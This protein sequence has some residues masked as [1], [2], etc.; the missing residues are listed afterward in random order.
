MLQEPLPNLAA[1]VNYLRQADIP[2]L[3][4]TA[5]ELAHMR[6][7]ED[8]VNGRKVASVI[9]H[10]P[11]MTL[12]MLAYME[13]HRRQRQISDITTI[14]RAVMMI[15][16]TPFFK[17]FEVMP[18]IEDTL[19]EYPQ[20]LIG[21]LRVIGR[22]RQASHFARDWAVLRHDLE[23]EEIIIAAL[24]HDAAEILLWCFAPGLMLRISAMTEKNP[25]L[26]SSAAQEAVLGCRISNLQ[27]ALVN[28]LHVPDLLRHLMD[29]A[30][31]E[32][33]RVRNVVH[34]ADLA[35]H[36]ARGWDN[37]ALP[38]DFA[39]ITNLIGISRDALIERIVRIA[40]SQDKQK[41]S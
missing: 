25:T 35:R 11:L 1:W 26:R 38:D 34:A 15:G 16:V 40:P 21:L 29:D 2:V 9:L 14:D 24:L 28:A 18:L 17:N 32:L 36:L 5:R 41:P 6:E 23:A 12:R 39:A 19:K 37:P 22:A 33:P 10:D 4:N 13:A 3:R 8:N 20:A 7:N 30:H 31:A 27:R